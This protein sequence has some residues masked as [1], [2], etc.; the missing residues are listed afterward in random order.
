MP[1]RRGGETTDS[2]VHGILPE[3]GNLVNG[4]TAFCHTTPSGNSDELR[5]HSENK[6]GLLETPDS[7][8]AVRLAIY[9]VGLEIV[10]LPFVFA[11]VG[12]VIAHIDYA[13]A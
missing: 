13:A 7:W 10:H 11:A 2:H 4:F 12:R 3:P 5:F 1:N 8:A 6:A 9:K